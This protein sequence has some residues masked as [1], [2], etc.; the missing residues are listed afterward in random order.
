MKHATARQI[1]ALPVRLDAQGEIEIALVTSRETRRWIVPK[2]WPMKGLKAHEAAAIEAREEAGLIGRIEKKKV[3]TYQYFK[4]RDA[5][6]DLCEVDLFRLWVDD[7]LA[8]FPEKGQRLVRWVNRHDAAAAVDEMGLK[9]LIQHLDV[10]G[11]AIEPAK[12]VASAER[13]RKRKSKTPPKKR[14]DAGGAAQAPKP[15]K[16]AKTAAH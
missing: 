8:D 13:K 9:V 3:G 14:P 11:H 16:S 2:G 15:R 6:F 4:R 12:R 10:A 7:E 5:R 1:G